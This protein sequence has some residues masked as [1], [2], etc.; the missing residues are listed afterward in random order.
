[1]P[2]RLVADPRVQTPPRLPEDYDLNKNDPSPILA[3]LVQ[4]VKDL[5]AATPAAP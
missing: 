5:E 1:M 3:D 2:K 4:D